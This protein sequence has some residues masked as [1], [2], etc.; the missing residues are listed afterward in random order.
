MVVRMMVPPSSW[1]GGDPPR[2]LSCLGS[3]GRAGVSGHWRSL[4]QALLSRTAIGQG[5][6][7][8]RQ[9]VHVVVCPRSV[10]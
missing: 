7:A 4:F 3:G 10:R 5:R 8:A 9:A 1:M 2:P 6:P